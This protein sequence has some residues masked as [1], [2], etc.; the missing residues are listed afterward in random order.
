VVA[1]PSFLE[2]FRIEA[3]IMAALDHPNCVKVYDFVEEPGRAYLVS[4]YV[5]GASLRRLVAEAGG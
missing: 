1:D 5:D 3:R 2:R 4:E